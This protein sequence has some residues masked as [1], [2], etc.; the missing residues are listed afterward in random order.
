MACSTAA[1]KKALAEA[2]ADPFEIAALAIERAER[3][4]LQ[5]LQLSAILQRGSGRSKQKLMPRSKKSG[6]ALVSPL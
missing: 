6:G 2:G 4:E 3:L 1:T 5:L